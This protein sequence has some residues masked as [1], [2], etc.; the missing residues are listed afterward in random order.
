M[1]MKNKIVKKDTSCRVLAKQEK[2]KEIL[3]GQLLKTPIIQIACEKLGISR[4]TFYRWKDEDDNFDKEIIKALIKGKS[5]INDMAESKL[6]AGIQG[7]NMTSIIFWLK[8]NHKSYSENKGKFPPEDV[9]PIELMI[10]TYDPRYHNKDGTDKTIDGKL[11]D[12][13]VEEEDTQPKKLE[14]S[15]EEDDEED[16]DDNYDD[17]DY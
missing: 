17:D 14:K 2:Q 9:E 15:K 7:G 10:T 11:V 8:N 13:E 4:S 3:V 6:I 16:E 5:L 1:L 12:E